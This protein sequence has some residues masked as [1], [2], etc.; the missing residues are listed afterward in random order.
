MRFEELNKPEIGDILEVEIGNEVVET[1][2]VGITDNDDYL[3]E[4]TSRT[5]IALLESRSDWD[6][7]M[8]GYKGDYGGAENWGRRNREDDE[9]HEIDRQRE[10]Q[11]AQYNQAGNF[12]LKYKDSG[13]HI[14]DQPYTGKA[15]AN[16]AA[17]MMIRSN[18]QVKGNLLIT[19]YGPGESQGVAEGS[20]DLASLRAKANEI[21]NRIDAI[22]KDGGRV[23]FNDPLS[24]QLKAIRSKIQQAKKKGVAEGFGDMVQKAKGMFGK[25]PSNNA[26]IPQV[27]A[28]LGKLVSSRKLQAAYD[29]DPDAIEDIEF[30]IDALKSGD[31]KSAAQT[32]R[33]LDSDFTDDAIESFVQRNGL[34]N[35]RLDDLFRSQGVAEGSEQDDPMAKS[36]GKY[37]YYAI[38]AEGYDE[39]QNPYP[40]GTKAHADFEEGYEFAYGDQNRRWL[41]ATPERLASAFNVKDRLHLLN[42]GVAEG[43]KV[44]TAKGHGDVVQG[45]NVKTVAKAD[46]GKN[47]LNLPKG[48]GDVVQPQKLKSVAKAQGV[49]EGFESKKFKVTYELQ[50]GDVK[51]KIMIGKDANAVAKYFEFKYRHKPISVV[52]Q[53][54]AEGS[55]FPGP[56]SDRELSKVG[57]QIKSSQGRDS[58]VTSPHQRK[59]WYNPNDSRSSKQQKLDYLKSLKGSQGV[60][61]AATPASVSKVLR[62]IGRH[63]PEWFDNYGMG[64]VEDTVVDMKDMGEFDGMSAEDALALVGQELESLYG[65]QGMGEGYTVTRGI[66]TERYQERAGLE[67]PF[68]AKNGKVVYYDKRE[69]KY[70]D[71]DTDMYIEYADWQAMNEAEYQGRDVELN[72]PMAGDVAKSKVYV[73]NPETGKVVKVNFGDKNMRIKKSNPDRRKSFRAR[74]NCENPGPKTKARYWSCRAW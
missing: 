54:V 47:K 56:L 61:E 59:D 58:N 20:E 28:V 5:G 4:T 7:N 29:I 6:S 68:S 38:T 41:A 10:Q 34:P 27:V 74:H 11:L 30:M 64:E 57:R 3:C 73:K 35:V 52:E 50:N 43:S 21:S 32:W 48:Y 36:L 44:K 19:A 71:P 14:N 46:L 45:T 63:H 51:E 33:T 15:A 24:R 53:G 65:Q 39:P 16:A 70:Y 55:T 17:Q 18:P 67:G 1:V 69:G 23:G 72:K 12:W 62:L 13:K 37:A 42:Q 26:V 9:H 49:A 8:P 60:A 22:V 2:I 40:V 25:K 66:D 31:I